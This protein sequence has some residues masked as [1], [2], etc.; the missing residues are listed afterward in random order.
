MRIL[1]VSDIHGDAGALRQVLTLP[2]AFDLLILVGDELYHGPRNPIV[3][4]YDPMEV[5]RILNSL[6]C[7]II[8][9]RGNCDAEVDQ[10]QLNF[11]MMQDYSLSVLND[12][13]TMI[14]HGHIYDPV[15]HAAELGYDLY[16]TGHTHLPILKRLD[17]NCI[18]LNPGSISLPKGNNPASYAYW[19]GG[20]IKLYTLDHQVFKTL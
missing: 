14:S 6:T 5:A 2:F 11:P 16:I 1:I 12:L 8:A 19:D 10:S 3:A 7:P 9:V 18:L 20:D 17:N 13:K 15:K 4:T